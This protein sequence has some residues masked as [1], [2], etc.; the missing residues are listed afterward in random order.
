VVIPRNIRESLNLRDGMP[1]AVIKQGTT[2]LLKKIEIP[3]IKT[4]KEVTKPFR[5]AARKSGFTKQDLDKLI[6]EV[7]AKKAK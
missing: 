1:L 6:E 3:K 2:I 4:W 5:I 7:R